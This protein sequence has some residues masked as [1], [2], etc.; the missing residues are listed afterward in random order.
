MTRPAIRAAV[1]GLAL[2]VALGVRADLAGQGPPPPPPP[3]PIPAPA[4]GIASGSGAISGV[5]VDA[6]TKEPLADAVV[7]LAAGGNRNAAERQMT[8]ARGRFVFRDLPAGDGY[9]IQVTKAGYFDGRHGPAG[10]RTPRPIALTEGQWFADAR[11]ELVRPGAI[12]GQVVD[13][14]GEPLVGAFVRTY[15][16]ILVAGRP[17]LAVSQTTKTDDRGMYRLSGLA[18]G[19]YIV[20]VP[21]ISNAIPAGIPVD[22]PKPFGPRIPGVV[23]SDTPAIAVDANNLLIAGNYPTPPVAA[24]GTS[25]AYATTYYP[26]VQRLADSTVVIVESGRDRLGVNIRV[27]PM[28]VWRVSGRV[29]ESSERT[30]HAP[31][32]RGA[33]RRGPGPWQ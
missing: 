19:R 7:A 8:D 18:A 24:G 29:G 22:E 27:D 16:Q 32:A 3:R 10:S 20:S 33:R 5:V 1:S 9:V 31:A 2:L 4:A 6:A 23:L 15:L 11:V 13:E 14:H 12:A 17:Q 21:S 30:R 26:G 28:P 25:R